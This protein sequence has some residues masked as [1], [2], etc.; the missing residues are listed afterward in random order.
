M[1][2]KHWIF[3][4]WDIGIEKNPFFTLNNFYLALGPKQ[5]DKTKV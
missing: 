4:Y 5:W 3:F 1:T 2:V